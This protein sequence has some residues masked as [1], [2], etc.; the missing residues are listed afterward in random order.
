M[1]V[2]FLV[3]FFNTS[4]MFCSCAE[5]YYGCRITHTNIKTLGPL[6]TVL[7]HQISSFPLHS[8]SQLDFKQLLVV[9]L[10]FGNCR[11]LV[12]Y[13]F[14]LYFWIGFFPFFVHFSFSSD[15]IANT[16]T[17]TKA[18]INWWLWVKHAWKMNKRFVVVLLLSVHTLWCLF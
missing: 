1:F 18:I 17:R 14:H 4:N 7:H 10:D 15:Q 9:C 8:K 12:V 3:G 13:P 6:F 5:L 16:T 2:S 11:L